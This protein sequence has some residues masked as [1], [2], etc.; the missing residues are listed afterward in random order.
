MTDDQIARKA[1]DMM[2]KTWDAMEHPDDDCYDMPVNYFID[3][4]ARRHGVK[5]I[6]DRNGWILGVQ[7]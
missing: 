2:I 4:F 1:V 5:V 3:D 7:D 6:T